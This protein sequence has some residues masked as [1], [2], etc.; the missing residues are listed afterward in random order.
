MVRFRRFAALL[1]LP[2]VAQLALAAKAIAC[3]RPTTEIAHAGGTMAGMNMGGAHGSA[4][5]T[6]QQRGSKPSPCDQPT[7]PGSC[8]P[9]AA[10]AS[11][12]LT[13]N[14]VGVASVR[15]SPMRIEGFVVVEPQSRTQQPE[16][17]PPRV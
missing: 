15:P 16:P 8:Q 7:A 13:A 3:V 10:C 14:A 2:L 1:V 11:G 9:M 6:S 17:P 12:A 4:D 5:A